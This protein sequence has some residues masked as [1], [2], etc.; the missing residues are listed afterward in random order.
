MILPIV[1]YG[2]P[3]LR[4][5]SK[6]ISKEYPHL[7]ELIKNMQETMRHSGGVGLAAP[8]IGKDIRLFLIDASGFAESKGLSE[9]QKNELKNFKKV[10]INPKII[11][12]SGELWDFKEGCL[13][14]PGIQENV[15]RKNT[16]E[17][18]YLDE[19]FTPQ[20]TI[21]TGIIARIFQHEYDHLEGKLFLDKLSELQKKLLQK[22]L[23]KIK[24]GKIKS[25]YPMR[26]FR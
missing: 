22:K 18:A 16:V 4:K 2:D 25:E 1:A 9:A 19:N 8:Q 13:S 24:K 17:A 26:F 15:Q 23:E 14:I 12:E 20:K 11:R 21:F 5:V 6:E 7:Q 3:I 10:F